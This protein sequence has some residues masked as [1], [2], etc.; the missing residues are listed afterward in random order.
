MKDQDLAVFRRFLREAFLDL[1]S[2]DFVFLGFFAV[3][4]ALA[5]SCKRILTYEPGASPRP[6][7]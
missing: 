7:S 4:R 5:I 3:L 6:L 2:D 1:A